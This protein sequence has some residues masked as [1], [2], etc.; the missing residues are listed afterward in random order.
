MPPEPRRARRAAQ[1]QRR[2]V[3]HCPQRRTH[4]VRTRLHVHRRL[5]QRGD[6]PEGKERRRERDEEVWTE[7]VHE[8]KEGRERVRERRREHERRLPLDGRD[9]GLVASRKERVHRQ[10]S[11]RGDLGESQGHTRRPERVVL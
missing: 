2:V 3:Q 5:G 7:G 9:R 8:D 4:R 10:P 6:V 1:Q 11:E